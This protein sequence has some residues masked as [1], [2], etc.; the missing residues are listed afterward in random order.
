MAKVIVAW[1]DP[2]MELD[3]QVPGESFQIA[4]NGAK[5][6]E[7][8]L[9]KEHEEELIAPLREL[10]GDLGQPVSKSPQASTS[11]GSPKAPCS[12]PGC[13]KELSREG[14]RKHMMTQH[15]MERPAAG[16]AVRLVFGSVHGAS[17]GIR[18]CPECKA[19][20][21]SPEEYQFD[22]PQGLGAHRRSVHN[23]M[24]T[25]S[26]PAASASA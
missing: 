11:G 4:L 3:E 17:V 20:G 9:C 1:C 19:A 7:I 10:L 14:M 18:E 16:D 8:D 22:T 24:G 26:K 23:V 15:G 12:Q 6:V 2:H 21:R 5:P 25:Q 13:G